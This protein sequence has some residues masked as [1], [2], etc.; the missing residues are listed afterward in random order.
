MGNF[1]GRGRPVGLLAAICLAAFSAVAGETAFA[2][3]DGAVSAATPPLVRLMTV[4]APTAVQ[5]RRFYGRVAAR[6]TV[7]LAFQVA[8]RIERLPLLEGDR[9]KA[10]SLVAELDLLNFQLA[11]E[12]AELNLEQAERDYRRN[13]KL[14]SR[15]AVSAVRAEDAETVRDLARVALSQARDDLAEATLTAPF[16]GLVAIRVV[17]N[18]TTVAAGQPVL[19]LHDMS[20]L[21]VEIDFPEQLLRR[22][23]SLGDVRFETV[24]DAGIGP[25]TLALR[26]YRAETAA[27]GQSYLVSLA[28]PPRHAGNLLPGA[29]TTVTAYLRQDDTDL[30]QL[31]V[32]A[33]QL[34]A[35][36]TAS[37][38]LFAG[39][40]DRGT[41]RRLRVAVVAIDGT[42]VAVQG[43][44]MP[45]QEIVA[46]GGHLLRDGQAVRR[47][48]GFDL[49]H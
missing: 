34:N 36:R 18:Y 20:E 6:Q 49:V 4:P 11:V 1:A 32:T 22:V 35:D 5:K 15:Q 13:T 30:I 41:V 28:V 27:I 2:R 47:F 10:G 45:G 12:R 40:A 48:Q 43:A 38:M 46:T 39:D 37:V 7:D 29:V 42:A 14:A 23:P 33:I 25:V 16:D 44:L 9:V 19:R 17:D 3:D 8:G 31:P 26:E 21:R 24:L